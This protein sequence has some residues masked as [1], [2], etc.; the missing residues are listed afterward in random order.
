[1]ELS[2][3]ANQRQKVLR[4]EILSEERERERERVHDIITVPLSALN[5]PS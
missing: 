1:M 5:P 4:T 2:M 3:L